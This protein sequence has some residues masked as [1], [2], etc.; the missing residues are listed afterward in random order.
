MIF[1][2][3]E[4]MNIFSGT[5]YIQAIATAV[6]R[7]IEIAD[8][9]VQICIFIFCL[10][11]SSIQEV[12]TMRE[13]AEELIRKIMLYARVVF[14]ALHDPRVQSGLDDLKTDLL[15]LVKYRILFPSLLSLLTGVTPVFLR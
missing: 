10:P 2:A 3:K 8:V 4:I 11:E 7:I 13:R 1:L 6:L 15:Q 12:Q 5:P 14:D 9:S